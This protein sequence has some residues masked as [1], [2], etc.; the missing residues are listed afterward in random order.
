MR[1]SLVVTTY[2]RPDALA[3][4]L[5]T[6]A[7]QR[8]AP[9]ELIIADDGSGPATRAV[10]D[11]FAAR[12]RVPCTTVRQEHAGFRAARLRNLAIAASRG[13]Y[14]VFV[15]GDMLLH[16]A[17]VRDHA[18]AAQRGSFVQ[19]MRIALDA[20]GTDAMLA[21]GALPPDGGSPR[22]ARGAR[23]LYARHSPTLARLSM[24]LA[25]RIVA[26]KSCNL[27]IWRDDLEAVNGFNEA[28]T[29]WGPEDKELVARLVHLGRRRRTLVFGGIA[30]HLHHAPAARDRRAANE[31]LY[32]DT[33]A[34]RTV[35]CEQ[36]LAS[37]LPQT[38]RWL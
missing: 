7:A 35:R 20:A 32:A 4:V 29:G 37:H 36:G 25:N 24:R 23:R 21:A 14:V 5:A 13:D 1:L 17:F 9:E 22:G 34:R 11:A 33:L 19:G 6:I 28:F 15:D 30:W 8:R 26:V 3:V 12:C 38:P 16:P 10:I 31:A 18:V 2:E 27:A